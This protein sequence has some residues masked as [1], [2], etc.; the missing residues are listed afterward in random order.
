MNDFELTVFLKKYLSAALTQISD[1][2]TYAKPDWGLH[3][4]NRKIL[5]K[6]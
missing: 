1:R 6:C 3:E 4:T 2:L 5:K